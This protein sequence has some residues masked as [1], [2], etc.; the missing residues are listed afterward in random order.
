MTEES[1]MEEPGDYEVGYGK[2]PARTKFRKGTSGNPGG[3]P[4]GMTAGRGNQL[5]L[6][7]AYRR[8]RVK[9]GDSVTTLPAIQAVMRGL[10]A[11]AAKDSGP[12]QRTLIATVQTIER[13]LAAQAATKAQEEADTPKMSDLEAARRIAFLLSRAARKSGQPVPSLLSE[14]NNS[15]DPSSD[16]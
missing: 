1:G 9:E 6:K 8:V 14:K 7:E 10:V 5:A 12:A 3:R 11:S 15:V 4:R 2:P 16:S 13:E